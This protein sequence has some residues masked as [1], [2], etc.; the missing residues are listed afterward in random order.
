MR[1]CRAPETGGAP[2]HR[3]TVSETM[4]ATDAEATI[5]R[6]YAALRAGEPLHPFFVD[7][8][9]VVKVGIGERLVGATAVAAGLRAQTRT[10]TAWVVESRDRHVGAADATG[11]GTGGF[12]WFGDEVFLAWTE[13]D[14]EVRHEFETRWTGGLV[15]RDGDWRFVSMHVSAADET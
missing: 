8:G 3:R 9:P 7:E 15:E 4:S 14:R 6:Y 5:D 13:T 1:A 12:A 10:T 11:D 2:F